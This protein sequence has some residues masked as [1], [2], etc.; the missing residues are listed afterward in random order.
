MEEVHLEKLQIHPE[1]VN[2]TTGRIRIPPPSQETSPIKLRKT[3]RL[4]FTKKNEGSEQASQESDFYRVWFPFL[5]LLGFILLSVGGFYFYQI[6]QK[7]KNSLEETLRTNS[8]FKNSFGSIEEQF[9]NLTKSNQDLR[10]EV[11]Q[12]EES[13]K[14][15]KLENASLQKKIDSLNNTREVLIIDST[16]ETTAPTTEK[17]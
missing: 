6:T 9:K 11:D 1:E 15:L 16:P 17:K 12:L 5:T 14:A 8:E 7:S 10:S 3:V 13:V 2:Q 4:P